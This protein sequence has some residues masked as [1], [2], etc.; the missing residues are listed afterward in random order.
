[1]D[2]WY[3]LDTSYSRFTFSFF[4]SFFFAYDFY[5]VP[6]FSLLLLFFF[7]FLF[8]SE[9][10]MKRG[11]FAVFDSVAGEM[12]GPPILQPNEAAARR[13]FQ[14][15]LFGQGSVMVSHPGDYA[16]FCLGSLDTETG[17]FTQEG[18]FRSMPMIT[19]DDLMRLRAVRDRGDQDELVD[20]GLELLERQEAANG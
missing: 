11:V 6:C 5:F 2:T 17:L 19:G 20:A 16:L 13:L 1:M 15:A 12:F 9:V 3:F 4:H 8:L 18:D 7:S 14:D 10:T